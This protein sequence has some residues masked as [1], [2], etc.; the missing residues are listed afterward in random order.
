MNEKYSVEMREL[1]LCAP[2]IFQPK[3]VTIKQ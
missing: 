1:T 2:Q 3:L